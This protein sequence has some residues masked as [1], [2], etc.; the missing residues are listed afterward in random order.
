MMIYLSIAQEFSNGGGDTA[1][2]EILNVILL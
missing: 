1:A 2:N